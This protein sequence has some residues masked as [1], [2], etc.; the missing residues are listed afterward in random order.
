MTTEKIFNLAVESQDQYCA[1]FTDLMD[2]PRG[3]LFHKG[4]PLW[5]RW[6]YAGPERYHNHGEALDTFP[7]I[8]RASVEHISGVNVW[9]GP[10]FNNFDRRT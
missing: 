9:L 2:D 7:D 10:Q 4:G 3:G 5:N 6:D 8:D 1:P